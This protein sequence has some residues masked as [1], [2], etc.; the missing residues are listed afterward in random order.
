MTGGKPMNILE[1]KGLSVEFSGFKAL[2]DLDFS[3]EEGELRVILGPNGAGKTT[4]MD[5]I[6]GKTKPTAGAIRFRGRNITGMD[7][8]QIARLGIGRKFQGPHLFDNMTVEENLQVAFQGYHTLGKAL[9][10]RKT[11]AFRE[12]MEEILEMINLKDK[13]S[14]VAINLSHGEKQWLEMG[15]LLA[16]DP[17]LIILDEPT[18]GMTAE[19][20]FKTGQLIE[21]LF[22]GRSIIVIEHDMAFVRQ[23]AR[24]VT[25][26]HQ[27]RLLAEGM[28]AEIEN[29]PKVQEVYLKEDSHA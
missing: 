28:L 20:T 17:E 2:T 12:R 10:F 1:T 23:V 21:T 4:L 13:A 27:G 25:V 26:L 18:T 14:H 3:L 15:M 11:R 7:T 19:E 5:L 24:K 16:Q 22:K 8:H 9:F 6:T 29:D